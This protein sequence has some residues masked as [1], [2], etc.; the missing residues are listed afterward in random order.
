MAVFGIYVILF[1]YSFIVASIFL[2]AATLLFTRSKKK[3]Y[4]IIVIITVFVLYLLFTQV[5][6]VRLK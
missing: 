6:H 4:Y 2:G 3:L 1:D 5:L